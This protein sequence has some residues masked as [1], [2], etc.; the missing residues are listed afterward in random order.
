MRFFCIEKPRR[1]EKGE[2][3]REKGEGRKE[4]SCGEGWDLDRLRIRVSGNSL[5]KSLFRG[6]QLWVEKLDKSC[7]LVIIVMRIKLNIMSKETLNLTIKSNIKQKAK[8][9]ASQKGISV[10]KLFEQAIESETIETEFVPI[11]GSVVERLMNVVEESDK[12][13]SVDY[14]LLRGK[15][16]RDRYE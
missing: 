6:G 8:L 13:T 14:K 7:A 3:R 5:G 11:P 1:R 9:L 10:S 4:P 16:I 12:R 15:V 2:G